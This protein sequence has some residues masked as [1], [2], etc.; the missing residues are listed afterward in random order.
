MYME[1]SKGQKTH[2]QEA[3]N[4]RMEPW[5]IVYTMCRS[6]YMRKATL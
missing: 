2:H 1:K 3:K 5:S 6:Q 4:N